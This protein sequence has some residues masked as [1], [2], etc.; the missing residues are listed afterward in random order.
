MKDKKDILSDWQL[1]DKPQVPSGF[2]DHFADNLMERIESESG[3]LGQLKK[4]K[5]PGVPDGFFDNLLSG[6][7]ADA[8]QKQEETYLVDQLNKRSLPEVPTNYF[9]QF[10]NAILEKVQN[11]EDRSAKRGR[12][13]SLRLITTITS[14][15]AAI[16][17]IFSIVDFSANDP[18]K[19]AAPIVEEANEMADNYLA[20]MD[21][22]EL[23]DYIIE[24]DIEIDD[25]TDLIEYEDYDDFSGEDIEDYYLD[26]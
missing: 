6:I 13:I 25:T 20:Y 12:V 23:I 5:K 18:Q 3:I 24:Y 9:E 8:N 10:E 19:G 1:R 14:I 22:D 21:E 15:A 7:E 26:L 2:F 4:S 16:A 11:M 17:I